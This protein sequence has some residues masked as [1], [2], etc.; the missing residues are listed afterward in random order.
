MSLSPS[1]RDSAAGSF[2]GLLV[3]APSLRRL[4]PNGLAWAFLDTYLGRMLGYPGP[5]RDLPSQRL[6]VVR[7]PFPR[8]PWSVPVES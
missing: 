6:S 7:C 8:G 3:L 1:V 2:W 4:E 5:E